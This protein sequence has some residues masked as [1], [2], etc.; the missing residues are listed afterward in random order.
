MK[1]RKKVKLKNNIG[2]VC[3]I[4]IIML[5]AVGV[6][7]AY[8][9]NSLNINAVITTGTINPIFSYAKIVR[10]NPE[11]NS[12]NVSISE[13]GKSMIIQAQ[14]GLPGYSFY[15]NYNVRNNGSIPVTCKLLN[16]E[17]DSSIILD[18]QIPAGG[19]QSL[20]GIGEGSFKITLGNVERNK[21]Y[22]FSINL[23]CQQ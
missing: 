16:N 6:G 18:S 14:N 1:K 10:E 8:F 9:V 4:S 22:N 23:F 7:Y 3:I 21:N 5:N 17:I 19:I 2:V 15:V 12:A 20:G 13:D 11:T